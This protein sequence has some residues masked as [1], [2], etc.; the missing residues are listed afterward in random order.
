[1]ERLKA[2]LKVLCIVH[3]APLFSIRKGVSMTKF[4]ALFQP[5]RI[6]TM[7][8]K[9]RIVMSSMGVLLVD[10]EGAV[11][12]YLLDYY[13]PRAAGG[14]GLVNTQ[15]ASVNV[16][17]KAM[18]CLGI[19]DDG[20]IEGL[21][22]LF[23]VIHE[24]GAKV[25]VQLMHHGYLIATAG[26]L[27]PGI[28]ARVP[29]ITSWMPSDMPIAEVSEQ[30]I[31]GYVEDFARAARRAQQAGADA[32]EFH[33]CH[34]C[35]PGAFMSPVTN[36]R[37]D[38]YGGSEENR[39]RFPLRIVERV[40]QTVGK[41]FPLTVRISAS[42][43]VD[44][45]TTIEEAMR[46]AAMFEEVGIDAI[47]V[48]A[49]IEYMTGLNIP[50]YAYPE[51]PMV[52]MATKIKGAVSVPVIAVGRITPELAEQVVAEG[53]A[54]FVAIGRPLLADPQLANKLKDG[55]HDDI[56]PCIY[57]NNCVRL[58]LPMT[59][60]VNP[61]LYRESIPL[62]PAVQ[63]PKKVMVVGG[64]LAGMQ[65]A[66]LLAERG[67]NVS[68][69]EKNNVLGGQWNIATQMPG[70]E[71]FASFT[72]YLKRSLDN[73][74]VS[75]KFGTEVTKD[76]V[77]E[78]KPDAVVVA[79]GA[80]PLLLNIPGADGKNVVQ[81]VD[82]ITGKAQVKGKAVVI[83][84]RFI[85]IE[86]SLWLAEQG[87]DASIIT[88]M[89]LGEDGNKLELFTFKTLTK[90][91]ID[92]RVPIYSHTPVVGITKG[93]VVTQWGQ[94]I[95]HIPADTVVMAV[96]AQSENKLAQELKGL[97]PEVYKIGDCEKPRDAASATYDA[98]RVAERI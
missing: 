33:A 42:D 82:V 30:D 15:C 6:G 14:V 51:G 63:K 23:Q 58:A 71:V 83:G 38:K 47:N 31:D 61:W 73:S 32:V 2:K 70:K 79:T 22:Q 87:K 7:E 97:V 13:R 19:F 36:L 28:T 92:L 49:G 66:V 17:A 8:L 29:S 90:R 69:Y 5:G 43:E 59:C 18:Y 88:L 26:L 39:M 76:M 9:N 3:L 40:R 34:G 37:T 72:E 74:K 60:T 44:D 81:A 64:G 86:V 65:A 48:S 11:T 93:S 55:R 24:E 4:S 62:P 95:F 91:L 25:C 41:D 1:M 53:G 52:Q 16:E 50:C 84:G 94:E 20:F 67:H 96:G 21:K 77:L 89:R 27:P 35:L 56:R 68:L 80:T 78:T 98:A 12:D 10:S 75:I 57:C 46:Q 54:D 85:G 45:G